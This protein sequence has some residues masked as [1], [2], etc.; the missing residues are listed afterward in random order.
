MNIEINKQ[1]QPLFDI[2]KC[3]GVF[4]VV[5]GHLIEPITHP[6]AQIIYK[7]IYLIH[8]PL[9]MFISGYFAKFNLK[10]IF[11]YTFIPYLVFQLITSL[12]SFKFESTTSFFSF[13]LTPRWTLWYLLSLFIWKLS[14]F[15]LEKLKRSLPI[16][17]IISLIIGLL[18]GFL[19]FDGY[20][21]SISRTIAFYP[22]FVLGYYFKHINFTYIGFFKKPY[23]K[24]IFAFVSILG[25]AMFFVFFKNISRASLYNSYMYNQIDGYSILT[26]LYTY[27]VGIV[28]IITLIIIVPNKNTF[29]TKIGAHS[30][31][32]YILHAFIVLLLRTFL[33]SLNINPILL[34]ITSLLL[35]VIIIIICI[36]IDI[37][38]KKLINLIKNKQKTF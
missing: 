4:L 37:C 27:V 14:V 30:F 19:S 17:L 29:L 2:L 3:I 34:I 32:I 15:F 10:K 38:I 18:I 12:I 7:C 21:L 6:V 28:S 22:F 9:F 11:L 26:R 16:I 25:I 20:I 36:I 24:I 23:I 35:T 8:M 5:F 1:R 33:Y 13:I 31:A